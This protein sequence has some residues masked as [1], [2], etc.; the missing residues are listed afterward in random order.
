MNKNPLVPFW[1]SLALLTGACQSLSG[2]GADDSGQRVLDVITSGGFAAAYDALAP[3]FEAQTGIRL[4]TSYGASSG[5]APDSI[6]ARLERGEE[7][8]VIIMSRSSLDNL[9][10]QGRIRPDSRK[11]LVRSLIGMA[12]RE[13]AP[14]PDI[15]T[16]EAFIKTLR[17]AGSIGYSASV[18]GTYISTDLLPRLGLW[19]ELAAKSRRIESERVAAVVAR[20]DVEI[21][22]QQV[23]EIVSVAG[24]TFAGP[25]PTEF[26]RVS[27]FSAGITA[28]TRNAADA[29]RLIDF[30]SSAE[31]ADTIAA[32]GLDPVVLERR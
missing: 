12:V 9:A 5:G 8:D 1:I 6:P 10:N 26:Q 32:T 4:V 17:D 16:P 30:L 27:S 21:G 24:A 13:G 7:F 25:I 2:P 19:D 29:Q 23:S 15:S 3:Q 18:S 22:F 31:V 14:V 28:R 11:D 20:G